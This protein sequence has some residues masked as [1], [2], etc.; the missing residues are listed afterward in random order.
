M[1]YKA[2]IIDDEK[3]ARESLKL[4]LETKF[5]EIDVVE[6]C[7]SADK[8]IEAIKKHK[9]QLVFLDVEMPNKNGFSVLDYFPNPDF[10]VIFVTAYENYS[11]KAIKVSTLDY[12]LKPINQEE[13]EIAIAKFKNRI[14][15]NDTSIHLFKDSDTQNSKLLVPCSYGFD[16]INID[17]IIYCQADRNYT[18]VKTTDKNHND[19]VV[20]K[21][22]K[23]FEKQLSEFNF[24]R[25]HNS[26]LVNV[27]HIRSYRKSQGGFLTMS[28]NDEISVSATKKEILL[29]FF[30]KI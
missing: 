26:F 4:R 21:T 12:L 24:L 1:K 10:E 16:F 13:L 28:N 17:D 11:L 19:K 18:I 7:S 22:I 14:A 5:Q 23:E 25:V 20:S 27:K 9:P 30:Q 3:D 29:N 8:G 6:C 2:V 15:K